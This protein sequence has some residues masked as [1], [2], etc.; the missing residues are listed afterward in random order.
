MDLTVR[1]QF[2]IIRVIQ[3]AGNDVLLLIRQ[4][5]DISLPAQIKLR[6]EKPNDWHLIERTSMPR[7]PCQNRRNLCRDVVIALAF[8]REHHLKYFVNLMPEVISSYFPPLVLSSSLST[9]S[10]SVSQGV[11]FSWIESNRYFS[12]LS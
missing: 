10:S 7:T 5:Q 1:P 12:S 2:W 3:S 9:A 8:D 6:A 4:Q 11:P